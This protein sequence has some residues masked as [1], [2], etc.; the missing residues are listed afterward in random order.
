MTTNATPDCLDKPLVSVVISACNSADTILRA[1]ASAWKQDYRPIEVIVVDDASTDGTQ[2][3]VCSIS[4]RDLRVIALSTKRGAA[5]ARNTGIQAALGKYVAFLDADDVWLP[6]K[7]S[8]QVRKME[9]NSDATLVTCDSSFV[10]PRGA[11]VS[12][13]HERQPPDS[14]SDAWVTLLAH[15]FIPTTTVLARR[16]DLI[17]AGGF[18]PEFRAGEDLDLWIRLGLLGEIAVIREVLVH[19]HDRPGSLMKGNRSQEYKIVWPMVS[20]H[21]KRQRHQLTSQQVRA[22][23]GQRCFSLASTLYEDCE[24][25]RSAVLFGRSTLSGFRTM[26]SLLNV[27]R[28]LLRPLW[29]QAA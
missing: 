7:L 14:G 20:G 17:V 1:I 12:R 21:L 15:N 4:H 16:T 10:G 13:S 5:M 9:R 18:N 23:T 3:L 28:A 6:K 2:E 25:L 27:P 24:Y 22:V 8:L 26:K 19:I 29:S 11:V